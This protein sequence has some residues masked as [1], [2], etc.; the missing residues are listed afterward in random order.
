MNG[1]GG[2]YIDLG[3]WAPACSFA[4][5]PLP[6]SCSYFH[7]SRVIIMTVYCGTYKCKQNFSGWQGRGGGT[8]SCPYLS[9]HEFVSASKPIFRTLSILFHSPFMTIGAL[10][11]SLAL[12]WGSGPRRSFDGE[13]PGTSGSVWGCVGCGWLWWC[14]SDGGECCVEDWLVFL[15]LQGP[16][17]WQDFDKNKQTKQNT[18]FSNYLY[19]FIIPKNQLISNSESSV[20]DRGA[21]GFRE[22]HYVIKYF[23]YCLVTPRTDQIKIS[24]F[25]NQQAPKMNSVMHNNN[26]TWPV[27]YSDFYNNLP[28][29]KILSFSK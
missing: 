3:N 17:W 19:E 20:E 9:W 12:T 27:F 11:D 7:C 1:G 18:E 25:Y 6:P 2:G 16:A 26:N 13:P 22:N 21:T 23:V 10:E 4:H 5:L 14:G 24:C 29:T 8:H 15:F 28:F